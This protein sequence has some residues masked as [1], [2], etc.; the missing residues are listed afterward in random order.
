MKKILLILILTAMSSLSRAQD[1]LGSMQLTNNGEISPAFLIDTKIV[2][3]VAGP[4]ASIDITQTFAN[5]SANWVEGIYRQPLPDGAAV[6]D[7]KIIIGERILS[8]ELKEKSE[9]KKIFQQAK[10][11]G[12]RTAIMDQSKEHQFHTR[13]A[14][15]PPWEEISVNIHFDLPVELV[16][17]QF[18]LRIPLTYTQAVVD[19]PSDRK[20]QNTSS[21]A[22]DQQVELSVYLD[23]GISI[24][25]VNS[26]TH[27]V[28]IIP[29][30]EGYFIQFSQGLERANKDFELVWEVDT[31]DQPIASLLSEQGP[32]GYYNLVLINP[33]KARQE[34]SPPRELILVVDQSGSMFGEAMNQ[35]QL[36]S[37]FAID[38]LR[39]IDTFNI[40]RFSTDN[41]ALFQQS[42]FANDEN[43]R[44]AHQ[45]IDALVS[46]GGTNI[47]DALENGLDRIS[48]KND[49]VQVIMMTDGAVENEDAV[50][51]LASQSSQT[52]HFFPVAIGPSPNDYFI[53]SMARTGNGMATFINRISQ[54]EERMQPL[55]TKLSVPTTTQLKLQYRDNSQLKSK[56]LP[57]LYAGRSVYQLVLTDQPLNSINLD[58]EQ[59]TGAW[60]VQLT[61]HEVDTGGAIARLWARQ[62]MQTLLD[63]AKLSGQW[64]ANKDE[65]LEIALKYNLLSP[66]TSFVVVD[67]QAVRPKNAPLISQK[68]DPSAVSLAGTAGNWRLY[69]F[70]MFAGLTLTLIGKR[71]GDA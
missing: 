57:D 9:A 51:R 53:R 63:Q 61:G 14:N 50:I 36:S 2:A 30:H 17:K 69:I 25:Q 65:V 20:L 15:I 10:A 40:V 35:A 67:E 38:T 60:K 64:D 66:Y 54:V 62:K 19:S 12:K 24:S 29:D 41:S 71:L 5:N 46:N 55:L 45:F 4:I 43:K 58:G 8:G 39:E 28:D 31:G 42:V 26:P 21:V 44:S 52:A 47:L 68:A 23:P 32:D 7:L 59:N 1:S 22:V 37:H 18:R 11:S 13:I 34:T 70:L 56:T 16:E 33:P 27:L 3:R 6:H 49:L 48:D